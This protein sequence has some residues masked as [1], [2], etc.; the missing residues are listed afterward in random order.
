MKKLI[1]VLAT[2]AL[3]AVGLVGFSGAPAQSADCPYT[4]CFD[5]N[6]NIRGPISIR[7]HHRATYKIAVLSGNAR[8]R[9]T[10]KLTVKRNKGGFSWTRVVRYKGKFTRITTP[11]LHRKGRYTVVGRYRPA[12]NSPFESSGELVTLRVRKRRG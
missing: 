5:T 10:I 4:G 2:T 8:P 3:M 11:R 1:A 6:L 7:R 12:A 9:G